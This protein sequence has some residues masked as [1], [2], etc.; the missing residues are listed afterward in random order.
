MNV[1]RILDGSG[2]R[3]QQVSLPPHDSYGPSR[4]AA[5]FVILLSGPVVHPAWPLILRET[6]NENVNH[7]KI[8]Q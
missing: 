7:C 1:T 8:Y 4:G 5:H 2:F 3:R 6:Y